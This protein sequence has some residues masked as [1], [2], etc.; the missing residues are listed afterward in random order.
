MYPLNFN[1][2][3]FFIVSGY[4]KKLQRQKSYVRHKQIKRSTG[5]FRIKCQEYL[6]SYCISFIITGYDRNSSL[7]T[8]A[9]SFLMS[10]KPLLVSQGYTLHITNGE[11]V[12]DGQSSSPACFL[13][14]CHGQLV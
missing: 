1:L 4:N 3:F 9:N 5:N 8:A 10:H 13:C 2:K 14:L 11:M 6:L 12:T 7:Y